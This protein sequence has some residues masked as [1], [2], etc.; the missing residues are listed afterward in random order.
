MKDFFNKMQPSFADFLKDSGTMLFLILEVMK[1]LISY[2][3]GL[4]E[5]E[6]LEKKILKLYLEF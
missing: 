5:V 2:L 1:T 4:F 6:F 3:I